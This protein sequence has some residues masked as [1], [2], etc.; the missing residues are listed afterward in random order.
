MTLDRRYLEPMVAARALGLPRCDAV[1]SAAVTFAG[2]NVC[3]LCLT[4]HH[5]GDRTV[6]AFKLDRR[7][8]LKG[9]AACFLLPASIPESV[10]ESPRLPAG[11][12]KKLEQDPVIFT[13]SAE[14]RIGNGGY[15]APRTRADAF[16]LDDTNVGTADDL[17][18]AAE[19]T[20]PL[21]WHL[22]EQY[23]DFWGNLSDEDQEKWPEEPE[24]GV[25]AWVRGL[26]PEAFAAL[27][28][29]VLAWLQSE[30]DY[31]NEE[32]EYFSVPAG[33]GDHAFQFFRDHFQGDPE[34]LLGVVVV[35]GTHPGSTYYA[36][37]LGVSVDEANRRA[38]QFGI[39]IRFARDA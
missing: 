14:G 23:Q 20:Q 1:C 30:P 31:I 29:T 7:G 9:L 28:Q 26:T 25:E 6:P 10:L 24:E 22:N 34:E 32:D 39:P 8:F 35:E 33:G 17:L 19:M 16:D 11:V 13:V 27:R 4:L 21:S 12:W 37:E 5:Y 38:E 15:E 3:G 2:H 36:A 18:D